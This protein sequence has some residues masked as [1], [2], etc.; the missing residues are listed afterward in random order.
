MNEIN[1]NPLPENFY[2]QE[3]WLKN[4]LN[5]YTEKALL[6]YEVMQRPVGGLVV[7]LSNVIEIN[8]NWPQDTHNLFKQAVGPLWD[9]EE[10]REKIYKSFKR[11]A[12][13]EKEPRLDVIAESLLYV[14]SL[15]EQNEIYIRKNFIDE[16]GMLDGN[17]AQFSQA[18]QLITRVHT[19]Q[20]IRLLAQ[21]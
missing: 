3:G 10:Y 11:R 19:G 18:M 7:S 5:F 20:I 1:P 8:R 14:R 13:D 6:P 21:R 15:F 4:I 17:I 9:P 12:V 16:I 2:N